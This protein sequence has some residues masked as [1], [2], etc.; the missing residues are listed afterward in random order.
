M[1]MPKPVK[2]A[3]LLITL[4]PAVPVVLGLLNTLLVAMGG[5]ALGAIPAESPFSLAV[6]VLR[7]VLAFFYI[8]LA[9]FATIPRWKLWLWVLAVLALG[10]LGQT[11]FWV[12]HV[13]PPAPARVRLEENVDPQAYLP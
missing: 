8:G 6:I 11:V 9:L 7:L 1:N 3:I 10:A 13:W 12:L 5:V 2:I 4:I